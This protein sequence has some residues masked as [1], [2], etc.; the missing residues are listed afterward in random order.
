M[1]YFLDFE[2]TQHAQRIISIGCVSEKGDKFHTYVQLSGNDKL[3]K[4]I[5]EL[6]GIT[7]ETLKEKGVSADE[8]FA[9]LSSF[10]DATR[11]DE[12]PE[13]YC[14]GD[15]DSIFCKNTV[16]YMT[17]LASM[18]YALYLARTMI[19]F[20]KTVKSFFKTQTPFGLKKMYTFLCEQEV[21]Q[22]HDA[23]EDATMLADVVERFEKFKVEDAAEIAAIPSNKIRTG[24]KAPALFVSWPQDKWAAD[25]GAKKNTPYKYTV[26]IGTREKYFKDMDTLVMW[27]IRYMTTGV[28]IKNETQ[29]AKVKERIKQS[30]KDGKTRY[31]CIFTE[32]KEN[33]NA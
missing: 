17:N 25:T 22:K 24:K 29:V 16:K 33:D 23:L 20:G 4:F 5:I 26:T 15:C 14:Y 32:R 31:N 2:S 21:Q 19:D 1:K 13:Y 28:S 9:N 8:A 11:N 3:S 27:I 30:L 7:K 12:M 18:T 6:T 10:V